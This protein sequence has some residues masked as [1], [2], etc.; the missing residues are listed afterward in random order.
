MLRQVSITLGDLRHYEINN[1][2]RG[3]KWKML[4]YTQTDVAKLI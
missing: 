3:R 2:R 4:Q 1:P